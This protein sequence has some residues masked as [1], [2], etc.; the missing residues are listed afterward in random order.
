MII[1]IK[2]WREYFLLLLVIFTLIIFFL[3]LPRV[4]REHYV[5]VLSDVP[6]LQA[7][8][9]QVEDVTIF[10]PTY[11]NTPDDLKAIYMTSWI[12]SQKSL[13]DPLVKLI[14]ETEINSLVI[15]IKDYSGKIAFKVQSPNLKKF[16]SEEVR[17]PDL[18][19]FLEELHQDG[20][21][22][23]ARIAVFQDPYFVGIRSDLAVKTKAGDKVWKD[24]KGLS[25]IDP[26]SVEYWN[27][28]VS[29]AK[30]AR[31]VGF[32]EVNFDYI[33]FPS[34]GDM[35][36]ISYPW[37]STTPKSDVLESFFEYLDSNLQD[38]G[39]V[40]SA[41]LFGMVTTSKNDMGI[42]Q[43]FE[44]TLPHFDYVSPMVYPSHYPPNFFGFKNPEAVPYE[45]IN[46][47]IKSAIERSILAS[48][49][50]KKI[51]PWLQDFGLKVAY[52]PNEVRAQIKSLRDLG[53]TS[54]MLWSPSNR[55]TRG[56]LD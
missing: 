39:L 38:T 15:D 1:L 53:L 5:L 28:I 50:P 35:T 44:K 13:R 36:D 6:H 46:L 23:I 4:L 24:K 31:A 19:E 22:L 42:G 41:D 30:E 29:I 10:R 7:E 2:K 14:K 45:I 32:D 20:V 17:M 8:V 18:R 37:S 33:R 34:D 3:L 54:W 43:I 47:S 21:Y 16:G 12:A 9:K 27:Y 25:W 11:I 51:R 55:Y 40:T 49:S 52:G 56:A 26:G 48:S